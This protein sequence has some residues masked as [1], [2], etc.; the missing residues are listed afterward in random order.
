MHLDENDSCLFGH[1]ASFDLRVVVLF[2]PY[3]YITTA[4]LS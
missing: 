4:C 3:L 2:V 1:I